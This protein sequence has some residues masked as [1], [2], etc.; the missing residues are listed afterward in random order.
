MSDSR[1]GFLDGFSLDSLGLFSDAIF[2]F[3]MTLLAVDLRLPE[4][5]AGGAT[6]QSELLKLLPG[7]IS[8]LITFWIAASY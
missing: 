2:A 8:F 7:F 6:I 1:D 4:M 3:S 5:V